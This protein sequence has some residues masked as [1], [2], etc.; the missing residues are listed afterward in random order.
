MENFSD[1]LARVEL[2]YKYGF[3]NK[4]GEQIIPCIYNDASLWVSCGL[5]FLEIDKNGD[6]SVKKEMK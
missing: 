5:V 3:I 2:N 4:R 1:G 6:V